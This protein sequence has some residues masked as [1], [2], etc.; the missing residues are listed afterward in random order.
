[1]QV[2]NATNGI[3]VWPTAALVQDACLTRTTQGRL[4]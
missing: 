1:L 3:A 4:A 2:H